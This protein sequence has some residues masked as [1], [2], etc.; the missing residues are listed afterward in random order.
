MASRTG[1]TFDTVRELGLGLAGVETETTRGTLALTVRGKMFAC[2]AVNRSADPDS[3]WVRLSF[4]DRDELI[5]ADPATYYVTDHYV[6]YRGVLVRLSRLH[7]DALSDLLGMAWRFVSTGGRRAAR[8]ASQR[9]RHPGH[10]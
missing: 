8:S 7:P 1:V 2:R 6:N 5:A 3:L 4:E 10:R 9:R